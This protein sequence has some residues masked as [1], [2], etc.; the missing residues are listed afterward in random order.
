MP[1]PLISNYFFV[2]L[3][4]ETNENQRLGRFNMTHPPGW[5]LLFPGEG[6]RLLSVDDNRVAYL[7]DSFIDPSRALDVEGC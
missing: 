5:V 6:Q 7:A 3:C 2:Y 4:C 1:N